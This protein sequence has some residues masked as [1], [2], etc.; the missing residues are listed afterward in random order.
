[1][2]I[3]EQCRR[4]A[5]FAAFC[6]LPDSP[7]PEASRSAL[8]RSSASNI[9]PNLEPLNPYADFYP[10]CCAAR[11]TPF[12]SRTPKAL[13]RLLVAAQ[14]QVA[15]KYASGSPLRDCAFAVLR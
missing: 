5:S 12:A 2:L 10:R 4:V 1:M 14:R 7:P 13:R 6:P 9:R 8:A 11:L 15:S 3:E